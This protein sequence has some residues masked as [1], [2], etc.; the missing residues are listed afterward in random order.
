VTQSSKAKKN[1]SESA[2]VAALAR[3]ANLTPEQRSEESRRVAKARWDGKTQDERKA[4]RAKGR[5]KSE[6]GA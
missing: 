6:A 1:T 5:E 2:R 3:H 4:E